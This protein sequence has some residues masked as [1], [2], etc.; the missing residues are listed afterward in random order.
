MVGWVSIISDKV[1]I[2]FGPSRECEHCH[3]KGWLEVWQT[4]RQQFAYSL[5]P[6]PKIYG[7]FFVRCRIC[8]WGFEVRKKDRVSVAELL[9]AGKDATKQSFDEMTGKDQTRLLIHLNRN[10]FTRILQNL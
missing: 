7:G 1:F 6:T 4:Y 10:R 2:G 8:H 5:I 3:N 9:E